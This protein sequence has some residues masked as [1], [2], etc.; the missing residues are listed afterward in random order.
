MKASRLGE[1]IAT[2]TF[3]ST[4]EERLTNPKE[5]TT[6]ASNI[7]YD[8][9]RSFLSLPFLWSPNRLCSQ[10]T[11]LRRK[12]TCGQLTRH[13]FL[14]VYNWRYNVV[15]LVMLVND[16]NAI[17]MRCTAAWELSC[18]NAFNPLSF[19]IRDLSEIRRGGGGGGRGMENRRGSQFFSKALMKEMTGKEGGSQ[20]TKLPWW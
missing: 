17:Y 20:E 15:C 16:R 9:C 8:L 1:H 14:Y 13:H 6:A 19:V 3:L 2:R 12:S 11:R 7:W 10:A 4:R 5:W 18:P